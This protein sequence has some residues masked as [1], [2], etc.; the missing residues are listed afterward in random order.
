M[1]RV[2]ERGVLRISAWDRHRWLVHGFSTRATGDFLE[3]PGDSEVAGAF[4]ASGFATATLKQVHSH[5]CVRA[6]EAW[7]DRRPVADAVLTDR[8]G[9]LV[10]VRTADCVPVLLADPVTQSVAA[11]HAGWR[12]AV[13]G[14]L[15]NAV[16]ALAAECG[17]R[18]P[19][20]EAAIGPGI[21]PC[22]F[23]VGEDVASRFSQDAV[24][25]G[26]AKPHVDLGSVLAGQLAAVGVETVHAT[27]ECTSCDLDRYFSYRAERGHTGRMLAVAGLRR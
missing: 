13:A 15:P 22:C 9:V 7:G 12:G 18:V 21:G 19:D 27:G 1:F 3:W 17:V 8:A 4:G 14:I 2:C 11:I 23:E 20:L 24:D 10:G 25:R 16:S 5:V 6:V 26:R